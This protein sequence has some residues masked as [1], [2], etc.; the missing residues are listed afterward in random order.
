ME[1][2]VAQQ[3]KEPIGSSRRYELDS[4]NQGGN[5]IRGEV[6]LIRTERGILVKGNFSTELDVVCSRCLGPFSCPIRFKIEEE[7]FAT[8]DVLSGA[9]LPPP[10]DAS[11]FTIDWHHV[12]DLSEAV[13]QCI[14]LATPMKP[15]C[16]PDCA[17]LCPHCGAN[18]NHG[19]C[20]CEIKIT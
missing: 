16:R 13:R 5:Q 17:G 6:E 3:L 14:L 11:A 15:V 20:S 8:V 7:Y 9:S 12:L 4:V 2:N 1:F 10:D 18:L 19:P